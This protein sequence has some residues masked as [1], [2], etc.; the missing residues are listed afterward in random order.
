MPGDLIHLVDHLSATTVTAARIKE[1]TAKDLVLSKIKK[2]VMVG[3]PDE[4]G[5]NLKP[6]ISR[7]QE[8]S[9]L[10]GCVLWGS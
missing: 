2:Y 10:D 3:W 5:T 6:Y 4:V 8:L 9:T 1:W 7:R